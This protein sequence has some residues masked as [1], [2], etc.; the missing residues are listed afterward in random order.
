MGKTKTAVLVG[1]EEKNLSGAEKY[2]IKQAKKLEEA[3]KEKASVSGVGLK[4]GERIKVVEGDA[5]VEEIK[6]RKPKKR[7]KNYTGVTTKIDKNKTYNVSDAI[8]I[9]KETSYSKF[10]GT[11]EVHL[12]VKKQGLTASTELPFSA[13]KSKRIEV[14]SDKTIENLKKGTI[15]FDVLLATA[16][17]MPK[18]VPFA[19]LLGPKGLMPNP[20]LG[21]LVKN[22]KAA[23][24]FS[25]NKLN[26]KTEKDA[27]LI[28]L[29]FGKVSQDEKELLVNLDAIM[30]AVN[31][32]L[33]D[34]AFIKATMS[35]S[36]KIEV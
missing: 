8:K 7:S 2:K 18:L 22:A 16:D 11:M 30:N 13:G 6:K 9:V 27:P 12:V 4:G 20:K 31:R 32:K 23:E 17:M 21:T 24:K 36:V 10:D 14:A 15:D 25:A 1:S 26:I 29:A 3:K 5:P 34:R 35:P 28:H 33:I 19:R